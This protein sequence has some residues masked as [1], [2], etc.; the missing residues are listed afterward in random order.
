[1]TDAGS[2]SSS[3]SRIKKNVKAFYKWKA[4]IYSGGFVRIEVIEKTPVS[5]GYCNKK[6]RWV[7]FEIECEICKSFKVTRDPPQHERTATRKAR[8]GTARR[9]SIAK[10]NDLFDTE[11]WRRPGTK[12]S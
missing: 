4:C 7:D 12:K 8:I 1:V 5:M 10:R 6:K 11:K 9:R 2:L 3:G